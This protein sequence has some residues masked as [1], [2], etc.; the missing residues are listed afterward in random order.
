MTQILRCLAVITLTSCG[1]VNGD[2]FASAG[3]PQAIGELE[4]ALRVCSEGPTVEG[5]DVSKW[6][7]RIDWDVVAESEV[8]FA[9]IRVSD[10]TGTFDEQFHRN[11]AEA[12]RVGLIR[13][14]Y[15]YFRP[16]QSVEE[17]VNIVLENMGPMEPGV[18]PPVIDVEDLNGYNALI[19]RRDV[20]EWVRRVEAALGVRPIVYTGPSFWNSHAQVLNL[21]DNPLWIAH[22]G[23]RCPDVPRQWT[24]WFFHQYTAT[25]RLA[26][27]S[28]DLDRNLFNGSL[29]ELEAL[30]GGVTECG[31]GLCS[32]DET[33][34]TCPDDCPVCS[35]IPAAGG[36]V[37]EESPCFTLSGPLEFWREEDEG[38][39]DHLYWTH[40]T[41]N[42]AAANYA[43]W[44]LR[45]E[46][47]GR[48]R[49][50]AYTASEWAMSRQAIYLIDHAGGQ[51][52]QV[53]DQGAADGWRILG[54]FRFE[55]DATYAV[56]LD[57]NTG[58]PNASSV[59]LAADDLRLIPLDV[60]VTSDAGLA[61]ADT[62]RPNTFGDV[63]V[64]QPSDMP[65]A[66]IGLRPS[67][68]VD[69]G[70]ARVIGQSRARN[71]GGCSAQGKPGVP[72]WW[73]LLI[74]GAMR[75]CRRI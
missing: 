12:K 20:A 1:P 36:V 54:D 75:G 44:S 16:G 33:G 60:P 35:R 56:R 40:T 24:D 29:A 71:T 38:H 22:W 43:T 30:A 15:Q 25:G 11:W 21:S 66:G 6:Q 5:I 8:R 41:D 57:D 65:D 19:L 7:G 23:V 31:D 28:G 4:H 69:G 13:G 39:G 3:D 55:P 59:K 63:E 52:E 74:L 46:E 58:E 72:V 68:E 70:E 26:G 17:Q 2:E 42:A 14:V 49:V 34:D 51:M 62:G 61:E 48:Y 73:V 53:I 45:F 18:L 67:G 47:A 64:T 50:E 32:G 10:G 27:I 37:S 9:F